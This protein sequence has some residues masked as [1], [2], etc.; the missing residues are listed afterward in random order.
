MK[1]PV[2]GESSS[3]CSTASSIWYQKRILSCFF[4]HLYDFQ[5][6]FSF[7]FSLS[8]KQMWVG[9]YLPSDL[10]FPVFLG[11]VFSFPLSFGVALALPFSVR[12]CWG[13]KRAWLT[14]LEVAPRSLGPGWW[15][16]RLP[17]ALSASTTT[18]GLHEIGNWSVLPGA[19]SKVLVDTWVVYGVISLG[20]T[21][22][23]LGQ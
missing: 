23:I 3:N 15:S 9:S 18:R 11:F 19:C 20:E 1:L 6:C 12:G 16:V 4:F 17:L 22:D 8:E 13:D 7:F 21:G 14:F 10:P 5:H 2:I